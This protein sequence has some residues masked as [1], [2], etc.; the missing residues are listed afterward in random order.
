MHEHRVMREWFAEEWTVLE[1]TIED[2]H[3]SEQHIIHQLQLRRSEMCRLCVIWGRTL[4]CLP[5]DRE[6]VPWGPSE[7]DLHIAAANIDS[8]YVS[9]AEEEEDG[10]V[11]DEIE[12]EELDFGLLECMDALDL[13]EAH[14]TEDEL[15]DAPSHGLPN[16]GLPNSMGYPT[17]WATQPWATHLNGLPNHGLPT[18]MGYPTCGLPT[19]MGYPTLWATHLY[20][21]PNLWATQ[22]W[23]T[24]FDGPPTSMGYPTCGLPIHGLPSLLGYPT[25]VAQIGLAHG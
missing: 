17:L 23:A 20:G 13:T 19:S 4:S 10:E 24:Q 12:D 25:W 9:K 2:V 6:L 18:S 3:E 22:P 5:P 11:Y 16:H 7:T 21:Q 1:K 8:D 14:Y 15:D